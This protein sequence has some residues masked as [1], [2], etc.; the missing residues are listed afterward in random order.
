MRH[1]LV[2]LAEHATARGIEFDF[3]AILGGLHH[4]YAWI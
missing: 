3:L 4:Q 1:L 2:S